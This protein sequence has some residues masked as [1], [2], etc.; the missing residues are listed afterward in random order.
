MR[1]LFSLVSVYLDARLLN[2]LVPLSPGDVRQALGNL[3]VTVHPVLILVFVNDDSRLRR[4]S[5]PRKTTLDYCYRLMISNV[6]HV[7]RTRT[8]VPVLS[9]LTSV[10]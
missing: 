4:V 5:F 2:F 6:C 10:K 7:L 1:L 3:S 8:S 9:T